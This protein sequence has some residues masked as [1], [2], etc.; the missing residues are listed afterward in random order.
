MA[1]AMLQAALDRRLGP[2]HD[3]VVSSAGTGATDG[4]PAPQHG[5]DAMARRGIDLTG[6][7]SRGITPAIIRRADRIVCMT[8]SHA[9]AVLAMAPSAA[10]KVA[11]LGEDVPDP[12]GGSG[13]DYETVARFLEPRIEALAAEI[14]TARQ[15]AGA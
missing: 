15:E 7:R 13:E 9:D 11:T 2:G 14:A 12:I 6:H 10:D 1:E 3:W 4:Y 5:V 8:R